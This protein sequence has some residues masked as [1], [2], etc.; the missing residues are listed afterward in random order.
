MAKSRKISI[1]K[2]FTGTSIPVGSKLGQILINSVDSKMIAGA[3]RATLTDGPQK[4]KLSAITQN[5][6][7]VAESPNKKPKE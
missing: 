7:K 2:R 1:G 6:I 5:S 3:V 4:V